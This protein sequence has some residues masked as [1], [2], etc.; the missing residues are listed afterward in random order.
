ML[1]LIASDKLRGSASAV[2]ASH[3]LADGAREAGWSVDECPLSDGGEGFLDV[4]G[5]ANRYSTVTGPLGDRVE[6][7][8]R[9]DGR[10]AII[11]SSLACGAVL[12]PSPRPRDA[13][14]A[15]TAGVG[16]VIRTAIDEGATTV[17]VGVGGSAST[18]GGRGA[19]EA[20][21]DVLPFSPS[22]DVIVA[23]DVDVTYLE[24]APVFSPQKGANPATV[25][26]LY[27]RLE[28]YALHLEERFARDVLTLQGGGA[29]GGL[30]G[31]LWAGGARLVSGFEFVAEHLNLGA[32]VERA[33]LVITCEGR[34]DATSLKGK[35]TGSV[36]AL[37]ASSA[38]PVAVVAGTVERLAV[39]PHIDATVWSLTELFGDEA[40]LHD[41]ARCLHDVARRICT[42][43]AQ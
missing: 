21:D 1:V 4:M 36:V 29:A 41:T 25:A 15:S 34:F 16:E 37:A 20:I 31:G 10:S 2:E 9:L 39:P 12:V 32:R 24:A 3:A 26:Q 33:D 28:R 19:L 7:A 38:T 23:C 6:V 17:I 30:A 42:A 11:E 5:G 35:V 14:A 18:D 22:L 40:S 27:E 13:M 8:W 43:H